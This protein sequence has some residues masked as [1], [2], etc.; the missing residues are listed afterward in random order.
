MLQGEFFFFKLHVA[1]FFFVIKKLMK[2]SKLDFC[3]FFT[4]IK[5]SLYPPTKI[6]VFVHTIEYVPC[7]DI[8]S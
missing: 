6:K 8:M 3:F 1:L 2:K 5:S 7:L 4:K